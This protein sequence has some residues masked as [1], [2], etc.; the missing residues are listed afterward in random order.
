MLPLS[1][2][3]ATHLV[4]SARM[5]V[6]ADGSPVSAAHRVDVAGVCLAL[7]LL[8]RS[9]TREVD[10]GEWMYARYPQPDYA[11]RA[12]D[13][14]TVPLGRLQVDLGRVSLA[15]VMAAQSRA[16]Y[17]RAS[18]AGE[19]SLGEAAIVAPGAREDMTKPR[20]RVSD[21]ATTLTF[22]VDQ[23]LAAVAHPHAD[24]TDDELAPAPFGYDPKVMS[25]FSSRY[26]P[27]VYLRL[28]AW[29]EAGAKLTR[30]WRAKRVRG[31]LLSLE[32]RAVEMHE[33]LGASGI[34]TP[35]ALEQQLLRPVAEDLRRVG[36]TFEW[37]Y[38]RSPIKNAVKCL[39]LKA[40]DPREACAP[41]RTRTP[42]AMRRPRPR[43][44]PSGL[45]ALRPSLPA[46]R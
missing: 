7:A 44:V 36:V 23:A 11:D 10:R 19:P 21:K 28:L 31:G 42:T 20:N 14:L 1:R 24:A 32:I 38:E 40:S 41:A 3:L 46:G 25:A 4:L 29:T 15:G 6:Y 9:A 22:K 5:S 2:H 13:T 27:L 18:I 26:S 45:R 8:S 33:A 39:R 35:S 16:I 30:G 17:I 34:P 12:L 37:A 43:P